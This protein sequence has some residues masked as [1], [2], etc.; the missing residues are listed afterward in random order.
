M[1][2][3]SNKRWKNRALATDFTNPFEKYE[4]KTVFLLKNIGLPFKLR[5]NRDNNINKLFYY[6]GII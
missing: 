2:F 3:L 5:Y 1:F 6:G 4:K